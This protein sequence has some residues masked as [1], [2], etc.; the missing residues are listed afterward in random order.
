METIVGK[1]KNIRKLPI[2]PLSMCIID[3]NILSIFTNFTLSSLL[4]IVVWFKL[5]DHLGL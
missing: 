5:N 2:P 3:Y 1:E 4:S